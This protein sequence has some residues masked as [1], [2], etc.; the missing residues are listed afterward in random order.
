MSRPRLVFVS[1]RFLFPLDSGGKIRTTQI[2]RG[3]KGGVFDITLLSPAQPA[4]VARH[5]EDLNAVCDRFHHWP[6]PQEWPL[7][8]YT[9]LRYIADAR[10]IS[11]RTDWHPA[12]ARLLESTLQDE[13]DIVVFDFLHAAVLAPSRL[14]VPSLLFTHNVEA[15]IYARHRDRA[16]NPVVRWLWSS[17]HRKMASFEQSALSRFDAVVAVS[18]RDKERFRADYG[19]KNTRV[20]P[21]GVDLERFAYRAPERSRDVVFLG[22]MDWLANQDAI[23]YFMDDIWPLITREVPTARMTVVGRAPPATLVERASR[24]EL[25]WTFT[26]FVDDV[27]SY[28]Q[29]SAVSVIP[30]RIGGGTRLKVFEAMAMGSPVVSTTVGVEGLPLEDREHF[31]AADSPEAF[32]AAVIA[33]LSD[34]EQRF[35][36]STAGRRYVEEHA[37]YRTVARAFETICT[38]AIPARRTETALRSA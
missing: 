22:S 10:P 13:A 4:Q 5:R 24:R 9:R 15:E 20:I 34:S 36:L 32:A 2:L 1:M 19:C 6:V 31:L 35:G 21:T 28:V 27:R 7:G 25:A 33:L 23:T 26:G 18:D 29:G 17:Q 16:A 14:E 3:M 12:A 30:L 8:R 38:S 37:S 11:V